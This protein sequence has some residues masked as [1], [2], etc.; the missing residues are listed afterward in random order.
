MADD[1]M[2]PSTDRYILLEHTHDQNGACNLEV[3]PPDCSHTAAAVA[4]L[5]QRGLVPTHAVRSGPA[6]VAT[7]AYRQ[8]WDTIFGGRQPVGVA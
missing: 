6:Q 3:H 4:N 7:D 8:G 1:K 5:R 2:P